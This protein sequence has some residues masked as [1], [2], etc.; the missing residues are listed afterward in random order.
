MGGDTLISQ[1]F[2]FLSA[3]FDTTSTTMSFALYHL[4]KNEAIQDKLRAQLKK[5]QK[6]HNGKLTYEAMQNVPYLDMIISETLRM[7]PVLPFLDRS[8]TKDYQVQGTDLVI[9]KGTVIFTSLY[10]IQRDPELYPNPDCFDPERFSEA[11]KHSIPSGAYM[12]FGEGPRMCIGMR[13]GLLQTKV[14]L[15]HIILN[16]KV[17]PCAATPENMSYDLKS[18]LILPRDGV[19]LNF[20]RVQE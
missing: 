2:T 14:G 18:V 19:P 12:P 3:G 16:F 1:S 7:Y 17:S 13:L 4:A 11:N 9:E 15:A 8:C 5:V 20:C 6:E 10:G